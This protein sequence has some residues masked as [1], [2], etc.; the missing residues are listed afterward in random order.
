MRKNRRK[1]FFFSASRLLFHSHCPDIEL[2][3]AKS[4]I[5]I[6]SYWRHGIGPYVSR[7]FGM[8]GHWWRK[9]RC[10]CRRYVCARNTEN[11]F[12]IHLH[13][14]EEIMYKAF[15]EVDF[16]ENSSNWIL[17]DDDHEI[18]QTDTIFFCKNNFWSNI[19]R[20]VKMRNLLKPEKY[21]VKSIL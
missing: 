3:G 1:C 21:F 11:T 9:R 16:T 19:A 8:G 13:L 14:R 10:I 6:D 20:C 4:P 7:N 15:H 5:Q 12:Q 18:F 17:F 2:G